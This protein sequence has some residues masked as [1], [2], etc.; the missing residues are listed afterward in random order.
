M[1]SSRN[2]KD[3]TGSCLDRVNIMEMTWFLKVNLNFS[4]VLILYRNRK[5]FVDLGGNTSCNPAQD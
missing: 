1:E 4:E 5:Q 3:F 2:R